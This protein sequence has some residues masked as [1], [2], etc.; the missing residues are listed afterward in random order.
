MFALMVQITRKTT[1][2]QSSRA[3]LCICICISID[4]AIGLVSV[5]IILFLDTFLFQK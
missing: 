5:F 2:S 3:L 1:F 4:G